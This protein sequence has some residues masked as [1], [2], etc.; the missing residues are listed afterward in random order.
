MTIEN[1]NTIEY[2]RHM[3]GKIQS[4]RQSSNELGDLPEGY[5]ANLCKE[6]RSEEAPCSQ[7]EMAFRLGVA[8]STYESWEASKAKPNAEALIKLLQIR[9][10]RRS[11]NLK[12]LLG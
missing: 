4:L 1:I 2:N 10:E 5:L 11:I 6:I 7:R 9:A 8:K 3:S 12:A